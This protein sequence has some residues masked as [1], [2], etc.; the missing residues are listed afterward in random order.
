MEEVLSKFSLVFREELRDIIS[1]ELD[2]V[3]TQLVLHETY[4]RRIDDLL[5][6]KKLL[7][8]PAKRK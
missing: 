1:S 6:G 3:K 5:K 7:H 8:Y 2:E 4:L